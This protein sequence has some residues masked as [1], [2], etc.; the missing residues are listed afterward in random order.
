MFMGNLC[1]FGSKWTIQA[2]EEC[3]NSTTELRPKTKTRGRGRKGRNLEIID[4]ICNNCS[5]ESCRNL[6]LCEWVGANAKKWH[7]QMRT[8]TFAT[9]VHDAIDLICANDVP[10]GI[11]V[12]APIRDA[13]GREEP[14]RGPA[15]KWRGPKWATKFILHMMCKCKIKWNEMTKAKAAPNRGNLIE[16]YSAIYNGHWHGHIFIFRYLKA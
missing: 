6:V 1:R 3:E 7:K 14:S 15:R 12:A 10:L 16:R 2:A 13:S 8:L 5:G 9:A 4:V 11:G